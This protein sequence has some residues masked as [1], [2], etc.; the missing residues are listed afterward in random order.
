MLERGKVGKY[1]VN[2]GRESYI[3]GSRRHNIMPADVSG[4]MKRRF[5]AS[6][7]VESRRGVRC[8]IKLTAGMALADTSLFRLSGTYVSSLPPRESRSQEPGDAARGREER[9]LN[10]R[11]WIARR[12]SGLSQRRLGN[13]DNVIRLISDKGAC[14][15]RRV[16]CRAGHSDSST[17]TIASC[18]QWVKT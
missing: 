2:V 4:K 9:E 11:D 3:A 6:P 8:R 18:L 15:C 17:G 7:R 1:I 16:H 13:C 5:R 14:P 10:R 12:Q